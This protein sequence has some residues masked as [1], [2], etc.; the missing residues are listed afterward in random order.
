MSERERALSLTSAAD[1]GTAPDEGCTVPG[2]TTV[3]E[4]GFSMSDTLQIV[5]AVAI[6]VAFVAVQRGLIDPSS[7]PSLVLNLAGSG[8]LAWLA[9]AEHQWGF[10]L[11][12]ASWAVVSAVGLRGRVGRRP[13][14]RKGP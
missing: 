5:G 2:L 1:L 10:L 12:E 7:Y 11:L 13:A 14:Q 6:L 9:F 8:L 3:H 4:R